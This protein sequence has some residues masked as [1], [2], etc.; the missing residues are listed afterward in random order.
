M[1]LLD[2]GLLIFTGA[3]LGNEAFYRWVLG[4]RQD[5]RNGG[6][7]YLAAQ[8]HGKNRVATLLWTPGGGEGTVVVINLSDAEAQTELRIDL[9]S[10]GMCNGRYQCSWE[11]AAGVAS[12]LPVMAKNNELSVPFN[13]APYGISVCRLSSI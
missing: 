9:C 1:A 12:G 2:G 3:E 5:V 11:S 6:C 10:A 8:C 4:L 7:N 13:F